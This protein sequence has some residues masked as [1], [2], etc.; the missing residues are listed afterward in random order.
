MFTVC[1]CSGEIDI[2]WVWLYELPY[3]YSHK[4]IDNIK[5]Q[6]DMQLS[7]EVQKEIDKQDIS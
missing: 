2:I 3:K 1:L 5:N 6:Y 4:L 7:K